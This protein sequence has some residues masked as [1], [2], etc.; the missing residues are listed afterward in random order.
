MRDVLLA[1]R[2][3]QV[4][5]DPRHDTAAFQ[6]LAQHHRGGVASQPGTPVSRSGRLSIRS[7]RLNPG[8]T[9]CSV[10]P[11]RASDAAV[12]LCPED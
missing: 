8:V 6:D 3:L 12:G 4:R 7:E 2:I 1:A 9:G 5:D 10:S 11:I